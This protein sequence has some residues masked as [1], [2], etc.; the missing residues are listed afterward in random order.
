MKKIVV[1]LFL[2][3]GATSLS[4]SQELNTLITGKWFVDS[5]KVGNEICE[6]SEGSS[7]LEFSYEG[8]YEIMMNAQ[9]EEGSWKLLK[10]KNELE[11]D[12]KSFDEN[13]KIEKI[14]ET[15]LLVS[16]KDEDIIYTMSLKR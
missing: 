3:L 1:L 6:F 16:A 13:L 2:T 5:M 11:F 9:K 8:K 14:T 10:E 15:E 7:W 12:K 4:Y